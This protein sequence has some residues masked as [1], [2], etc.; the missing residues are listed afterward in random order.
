MQGGHLDKGGRFR[1]SQEDVE[2]RCASVLLGAS[3]GEG[4][5]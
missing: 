1:W 4:G 3:G 5:V 2:N